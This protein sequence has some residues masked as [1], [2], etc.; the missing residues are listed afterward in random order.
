MYSRLLNPKW[1]FG[2]GNGKNFLGVPDGLFQQIDK[3]GR[4]KKRKRMRG[5]WEEQR[6]EEVLG[7]WGHFGW[8]MSFYFLLGVRRKKWGKESNR[9]KRSNSPSMY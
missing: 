7:L 2:L 9:L 1:L 6:E 4:W 3:R 5:V 8:F